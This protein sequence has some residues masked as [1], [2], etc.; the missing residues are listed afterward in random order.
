MQKH[1]F[2]QCLSLNEVT[3]MAISAKTVVKSLLTLRMVSFFFLLMITLLK[4]TPM[5]FKSLQQRPFK[6]ANFKRTVRN[7]I[8]F[9]MR[10]IINLKSDN[11][12]L[13]IIDTLPYCCLDV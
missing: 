12:V 10:T 13:P 7:F 1:R 5:L 4:I 2:L 8:I 11:P 3:V 6:K 9:Y